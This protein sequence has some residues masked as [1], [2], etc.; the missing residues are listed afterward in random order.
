MSL[1]SKEK[2][3]DFEYIGELTGKKYDGSF[4]VLCI[5][6][7]GLKHTM[8]LEKTRLLGNYTNPTDELFGL[9]LILSSLRVKIKDGPEWWRQSAGGN[10]IDDEGVLVKLYQKI[11]EAEVQWKEDLKKKTQEAVSTTPSVSQ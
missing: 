11:G 9:A 8:E 2:V 6:N 5:L 1:P 10:L 7:T 3:F 4:T